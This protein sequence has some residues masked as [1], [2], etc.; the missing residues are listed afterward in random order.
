IKDPSAQS[1]LSQ[2]IDQW[3]KGLLA[4]NIQL[5]LSEAIDSTGNAALKTK[6]EAILTKTGEGQLMALYEDCLEGGDP[7]RGMRIIQSNQTA[8]C[9]RCHAM[10]DF[11]GDAGPQLSGVGKRL[12]RKE[13]LQSLIEPSASIAPGFGYVS[14]DLNDGSSVGGTF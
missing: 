5:E 1:A 8:Q 10:G 6:I 3:E 13:L 9:M 14:L 12:S 7:R 2:Y 4:G 11:G